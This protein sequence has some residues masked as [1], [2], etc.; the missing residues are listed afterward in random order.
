MKY[1]IFPIPEPRTK[2]RGRPLGSKNGILF[3]ESY[4]FYTLNEN[5]ITMNPKEGTLFRRGK[6]IMRLK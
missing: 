2:K 1:N 5:G 6:Y 3:S 4:R